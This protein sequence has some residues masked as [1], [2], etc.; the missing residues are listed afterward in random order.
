MFP[1]QTGCTK[2]LKADTRASR[3]NM[4]ER[5]YEEIFCSNMM[6]TNQDIVA[7]G[8]KENMA[9]IFIENSEHG[10]KHT[11]LMTAR[12]RQVSQLGRRVL[13]VD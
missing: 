9:D 1:F 13:R 8:L 12:K 7:D 11:A 6:K 4:T 3:A 5:G 10:R 2:L